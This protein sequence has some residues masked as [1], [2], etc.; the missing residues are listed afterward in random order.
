VLADPP[1]EHYL[2]LPGGA[3]H[4]GND[5]DA[6]AHIFATDDCH[7]LVGIIVVGGTWDEMGQA[8]HSVGFGPV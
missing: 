8:A 2:P 7:D 1:S 5:T 6:V 4:A 3:A